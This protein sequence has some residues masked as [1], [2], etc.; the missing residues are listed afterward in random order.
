MISCVMEKAEKRTHLIAKNEIIYSEKGHLVV[1]YLKTIDLVVSYL[2][3]CNFVVGY[4]KTI[5]LGCELYRNKLT[6]SYFIS[7]VCKLVVDYLRCMLL[8]RGLYQK[9]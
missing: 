3:L 5:L 2:N 9:Y 6:W 4:I 8:G 7:N 1:D